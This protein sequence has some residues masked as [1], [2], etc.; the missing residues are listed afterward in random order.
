MIE[1]IVELRS[2]LG[3]RVIAKED[4]EKKSDDYL[5]DSLIDLQEESNNIGTIDLTE[6]VTDKI[7]SPGLEDN[8]EKVKPNVKEQKTNSNMNLDEAMQDL[9][10]RM[11]DSR[12]Y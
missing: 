11:F 2:K 12:K 5:Q 9:V 1:S 6:G 10:S 7:V 4:L 8:E 3:K